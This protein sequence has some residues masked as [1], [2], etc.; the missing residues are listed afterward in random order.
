LQSVLEW[1]VDKVYWS[2]KCWFFDFNWLPWQRP[3]R[4]Q[5]RGPDR[6]YSNTYLSLVQRSWK[7]V[8]WILR[9][10]LYKFLC[11]KLRDHWIE[12]HQI[13][14]MCT[15]IT[16]DYDAEIKIAIFQ[17]VWKRQRDE[18]RSSANFEITERKFTKFGHDIARLLPFNLLKADLRS[19]NPLSNAKAKAKSNGHSTRRLRTSPIFNWL[20]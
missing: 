7:S 9:R 8:Q 3:L 15:E 16:A 13:S 19:A 12:S 5:K 20:P 18:W 17:S 14:T 10:R 4:N 2:K 6:S 11:L 1:L